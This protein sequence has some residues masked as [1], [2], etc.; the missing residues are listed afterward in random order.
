MVTIYKVIIAALTLSVEES[1][2]GVK[3]NAQDNP[4]MLYVKSVKRMGQIILE[5]VIEPLKRCNFTYQFTKSCE[6]EKECLKVLHRFTR[7]VIRRRREE[8]KTK[9]PNELRQSKKQAFLDLLLQ[10][11]EKDGNYILSDDDVQEEVD[12]FMF[13]VSLYQ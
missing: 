10:M 1:A 13:E 6:D 7:D 5:R 3:I 12:T 4:Q 8:L 11:T 9:A 2:M